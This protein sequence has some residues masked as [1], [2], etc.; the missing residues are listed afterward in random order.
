VVSPTPSAILYVDGSSDL[1]LRPYFEDEYNDLFY[2][3]T[4]RNDGRGNLHL[5]KW[6]RIQQV[7]RAAIRLVREGTGATLLRE[8]PWFVEQV[9]GTTLG[10]KIV[11][12]DPQGAQKGKDP[13]LIAFRIPLGRGTPAVGLETL[14]SAGKPL[15]GS[16]RRIRVIAPPPAEIVLPLLALVPLVAMVLIA[17]RRTRKYGRP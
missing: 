9:Q 2:A 7:P 11:P 12:Y 14:D 5:M 1:Y 6:E 4:I 10:Y 8:E 16:A 13:S 3:R 17:V 15:S